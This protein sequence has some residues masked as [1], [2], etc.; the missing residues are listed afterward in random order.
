MPDLAGS[1]INKKDNFILDEII[2]IMFDFTI[3]ECKG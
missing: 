3:A 2:F 1:S